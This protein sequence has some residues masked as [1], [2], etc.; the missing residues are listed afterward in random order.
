[1]QNSKGCCHFKAKQNT[2]N[3]MVRIPWG[4]D[5]P[6]PSS[7]SLDEENELRDFCPKHRI[8]GL[9]SCKAEYQI[10]PVSAKMIC[11]YFFWNGFDQNF[12]NLIKASTQQI[13]TGE[14]LWL[15]IPYPV[16]LW[17]QSEKAAQLTSP[18]SEALLNV[19]EK[20]SHWQPFNKD[21]ESRSNWLQICSISIC[22]LLNL[23]RSLSF[24]LK[25]NI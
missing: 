23:L 2:I 12:T 18:L 9:V 3:L 10:R 7:F 13:Y 1:M 14:P 20:D 4:S 19:M 5:S 16:A 6:L 25:V 24:S 21:T 17:L 22:K 15:V 8:T 11:W